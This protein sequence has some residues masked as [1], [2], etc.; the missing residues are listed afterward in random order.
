MSLFT[1]EV[2]EGYNFEDNS[3]SGNDLWSVCNSPVHF[4]WRCRTP[5]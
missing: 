5:M 1:K 4:L 2:K 3:C